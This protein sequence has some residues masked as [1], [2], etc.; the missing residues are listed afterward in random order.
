MNYN[1]GITK[2]LEGLE[3]YIGLYS[4]DYYLEFKTKSGGIEDKIKESLR[5]GRLIKIGIVGEIKSGKSSF[6]NSLI[7]DGADVLPKASTPMTAALTKIHYS[8]KNRVKIVFYTK[9]DW[10]RVQEY[11]NE[12]DV[13][14]QNEYNEY[15]KRMTANNKLMATPMT[16][17]KKE[18]YK[19]VCHENIPIQYRSCKELI[20]MAIKSN[21][22]IEDYLGKET[23]INCSDL[24]K[25]LDD[26]IGA[27]GN[28]TSIV[29][30]VELGMNYEL[31]NGIEIFD[32]PGM[33]DPVVS[34]GETTKK[35]LQDCD[36]VFLLSYSGQ[37]LT[38]EDIS[39]M[40]E[41]LP[42]EGVKNIIIVGSKLDSGVLDNSKFKEFP[43]ALAYSKK[44]YNEQ[45]IS[46]VKKCI[47]SR[48]YLEAVMKIEESLP[49]VYIS[50]LMYDV[51][52]KNE[53]GI[54]L[55]KYEENIIKQ[56]KTRFE[57]FSEEKKLLLQFSGIPEVRSKKLKVIKSNKDNLIEKKNKTIVEDSKF[58]LLSILSQ[59][60]TQLNDNF[61]KVKNGDIDILERQL[62]DAQSSLDSMRTVV[63]NIFQ[64]YLLDAISIL[65]GL[66]NEIDLEIDNHSL[67]NIR[68]EGHN[69]YHTEKVGIFKKEVITERVITKSASISDVISNM[70]NYVARCKKMSNEIFSKAVNVSKLKKEIKDVVLETFE[71]SNQEFNE[72]DILIP[73][74][75]VVSKISI[76]K[77]EVDMD[78]YERM[79]VDS[80][81]SASV[82]GDQIEVLKLQQNRT[83]NQIAK[84]LKSEVK[85]CESATKTIMTEQSIFFVDNIIKVLNENLKLIK[86]QLSNKEKSIAQYNKFERLLIEYT[87]VVKNMEM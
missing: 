79:I 72:N 67:F 62:H 39:F 6:L 53:K 41:T 43:K 15:Y 16:I 65:N 3:Q 45:A 33:N 85:K 1:D 56:F 70:R 36:I 82:S 64:K 87:Q 75:I 21:I 51:A 30:Y 58:I 63:G 77:I 29:K 69:E 13:C 14:L 22:N 34:R 8:D 46:N 32:T 35:F 10:E 2:I 86:N 17:Q 57:G 84:K 20:E 27:E 81:T 52:K 9:K 47:G 61:S 55:E 5:E 25:E 80:F 74:D 54:S 66:G 23:E 42:R 76:P 38:Q 19:S 60:R 50:S 26:Y 73:L 11:A 68:E 4:R 59:I 31:L 48:N 49:P 83:M 71:K 7:F 18:E 40:A 28:Y 37:F 78:E 24:A 12:Y 44:L